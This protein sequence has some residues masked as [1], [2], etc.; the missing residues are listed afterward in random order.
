MSGSKRKNKI[1]FF[2]LVALGL[3]GVAAWYLH[4]TNIP[5][6]EPAGTVGEKERNLILFTLGL[7]LVVVIPVYI[8][9]FAFAWRYREG[10][11]KPAKY[12]PELAGNRYAEAVWWLI[13]T[14][15][16]TILSVVTWN[17]SHALDPY[18]SLASSTRPLRIQVI[19]MQWKWLF[20]YPDQHV[21]SV[22]FFQF[23][24]DTPLDFQITSDAP[25]NSLW[26]PQLGSQIYAMPGMT[27]KLHLQADKTGNFN[28][29]SANISGEGF[30]RMTFVAK[31]SSQ[32]AFNDWMNQAKQS[33]DKL[34]VAAYQQLAC[35][36]E[37]PVRYYAPVQDGLFQ[38]QVTK[39]I[40]PTTTDGKS[41]HF[42]PMVSMGDD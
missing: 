24:K 5:V 40:V 18:R 13:P 28:G 22:N 26:I 15:I 7:S 33:G 9:L 39:Y 30:A 37:S 35:P 29:W 6:L 38:A 36:G 12:S 16:I 11:K 14:V 1:V 31:S 3:I 10:N 27:T 23:P 2:A 42:A 34:N 4:R 21:A 25:M 41:Y 32:S 19:A 17:S 8:M 20:I